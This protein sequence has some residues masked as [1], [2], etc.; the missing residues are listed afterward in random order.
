MMEHS[1]QRQTDRF[2]L[3]KNIFL[4]EERDCYHAPLF[5]LLINHKTHVQ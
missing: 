4:P 5:L 3:Y 1:M 2:K